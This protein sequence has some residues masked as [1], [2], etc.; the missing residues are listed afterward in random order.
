MLRLSDERGRV[1]YA[2]LTGLAGDDATL[3]IGGVERTVPVGELARWWRGEF[4][5]FW[6]TPPGYRQGEP[7][8]RELAR[9]ITQQLNRIDGQDAAQTGE[10]ALRTRIV[11][12]QLAQGLTPDGV[13]GPL[14]LMQ[15]NRFGGIDEPRLGS[16]SSGGPS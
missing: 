1:A 8:S 13:A 16:R 6:R 4:A 9:W 11:A 14:T 7:T 10:A 15:L 5:T 2:L 12:F 3:S